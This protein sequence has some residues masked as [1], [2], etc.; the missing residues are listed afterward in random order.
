MACASNDLP[1]PASPHQQHRRIRLGHT[2]RLSLDL[3]GQR[4]GT[5]KIDDAMLR[6]A[7]QSLGQRQLTPGFLEFRLQAGEAVHHVRIPG[8]LVHGVSW[9]AQDPL[10]RAGQ[11][12]EPM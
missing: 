11:L 9:W 6:P 4:T 3:L 12:V 7:L 5:D 1:V 2:P 10:P 8:L